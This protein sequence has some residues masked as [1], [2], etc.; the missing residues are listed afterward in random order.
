MMKFLCAIFI[1]STMCMA[2]ALSIDNNGAYASGSL[3]VRDTMKFSNGATLCFYKQGQDAMSLEGAFL[4]SGVAVDTGH[5][6]VKK[7]FRYITN[8]TWQ[9][10]TL[11]S[12]YINN[13]TNWAQSNAFPDALVHLDSLL[14]ATGMISTGIKM[15]VW[16]WYRDFHNNPEFDLSQPC[17]NYNTIFYIQTQTNKMKVMV[18]KFYTHFDW[19]GLTRNLDSIQILWAVDS[20]GNGK[21]QT[22]TSI[23]TTVPSNKKAPAIT[24]TKKTS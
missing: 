8:G 22:P 5:A 18:S 23:K 3:L 14:N 17:K 20:L 6:I 13:D 24:A 1:L 11:V 19:A 21:F 15:G 10:D 7:G 12:V 2:S 16:I 9:K 4:F